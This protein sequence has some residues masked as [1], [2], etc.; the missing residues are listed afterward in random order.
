[1][2]FR[3]SSHREVDPSLEEDLRHSSSERSHHFSPVENGFF[4]AYFLSGRLSF[5]LASPVRPT[6]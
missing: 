5:R 2:R 6:V 4:L 1:M 3:L